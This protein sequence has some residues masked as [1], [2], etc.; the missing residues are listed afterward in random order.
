MEEA[1]R[2]KLLANSAIAAAVS[3]IVWGARPDSAALTPAKGQITLQQVAG[4]RNYTHSGADDLTDPLIQFDY[5]ATSQFQAW[6]I[7]RLVTAEMETPGTI[8][9]VS[10]PAAFLESQQ[11]FDPEDVDGGA[12]VY[13]R[14]ADWRVY[15]QPAN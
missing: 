8:S 2:A 7:E 3:K 6:T 1:L 14:I 10:F 9:G 15:S 13:R 5:W 12:T 11:D 4:G